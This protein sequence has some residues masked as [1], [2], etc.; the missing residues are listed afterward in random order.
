MDDLLGI[1]VLLGIIGIVSLFVGFLLCIVHC[2]SRNKSGRNITQSDNGLPIN[3]ELGEIEFR[4]S[5]ITG[6][7]LSQERQ[8]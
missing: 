2:Q 6:D 8:E 1:Y 4:E 7:I 5:E 3:T